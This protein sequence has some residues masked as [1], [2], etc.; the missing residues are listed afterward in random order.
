MRR[1]SPVTAEEQ[2]VFQKAQQALRAADKA[3]AKPAES[4]SALA[5][6]PKRGRPLKPRQK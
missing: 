4:A 3:A 5:A 6:K 1:T 2:A